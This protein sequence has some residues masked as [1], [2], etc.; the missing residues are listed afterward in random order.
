MLTADPVGTVMVAGRFESARMDRTLLGGS[1][2]A[3]T[4]SEPGLCFSGANLMPLAGDRQSLW[5]IADALRSRGR[6]CASIVGRAELVEPLWERTRPWWGPARQ[7]RSDQPLLACPDVPAVAPD[8]RVAPV[9]VSRIDDYFPAA[10]A[11]FTE[12]VGVDPTAGDGGVSYRARVKELLSARRAFAI[13]DGP[14]VVYKAEVGALSRRVGLIQGV[15][16][17]PA[18]RGRG[19]SGP[20]TAAVVQAVQRWG[21]LPSLYVNSFN[22]PARRTYVRVGF[23]QVGTFASVLF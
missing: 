16:V 22:E 6:R 18:Y 11:M 4:R 13:F 10:V 21:R 5:S 9:D 1:F 3:S 2:W 15:W 12:E 23:E 17:N 14:T 19:I 20:A 8:G 7:V